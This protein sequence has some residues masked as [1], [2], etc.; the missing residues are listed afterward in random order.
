M[1]AIQVKYSCFACGVLRQLVTI[2]SR[3][4]EDV[5]EW[6][7]KTCIPALCRDHD[8]RSPGCHP[9][10]LSEILIPILDQNKIGGI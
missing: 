7:E 10:K 5:C 9:D 4:G 3:Q 8:Q 6:M 1:R 2:H